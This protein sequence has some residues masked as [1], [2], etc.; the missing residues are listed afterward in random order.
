MGSGQGFYVCFCHTHGRWKSLGQGSNSR[1]H[2]NLRHSFGNTR[3]L[4]RCT[5]GDLPQ[6]F[7]FRGSREPSMC[8]YG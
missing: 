1:C 8:V 4:T 6:G 7:Y 3:S 2:L 5:T